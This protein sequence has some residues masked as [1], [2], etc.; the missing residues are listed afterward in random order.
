[1]MAR[2]NCIPQLLKVILSLF[3]VHANVQ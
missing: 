3:K 1:M 2:A